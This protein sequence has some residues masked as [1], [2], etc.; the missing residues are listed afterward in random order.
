MI[1][2]V[3]SHGNMLYRYLY[4]QFSWLTVENFHTYSI[5]SIAMCLIINSML[6]D[7]VAYTFWCLGNFWR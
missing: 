5:L 1:A 4:A 6:I 7:I 3:V 2:K